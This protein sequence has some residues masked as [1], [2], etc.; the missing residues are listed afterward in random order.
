[1]TRPATPMGMHE[2]RR[3]QFG[4][5]VKARVGYVF[6]KK[7]LKDTSNIWTHVWSTKYN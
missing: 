2:N 5:T 7:I 4:E 6:Q 3:G 1:M